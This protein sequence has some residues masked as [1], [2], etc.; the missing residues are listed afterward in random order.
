[1]AKAKDAYSTDELTSLGPQPIYDGYT[2]TQVAFPLGGIGTG[3]LSLTARGSLVDWE[4]FNRPNKGSVLPYSFFTIW[5]RAEG[6]DPVTRV[7]QGPPAPPFT[8]EGGGGYRGLGFGVTREDG[9]GLPHMRS[10][11]FRGEFPLAWVDFAD[12]KL[13]VQVK[14]EAYSP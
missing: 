7:L 14:L 2:A 8:G 1:M 4:I 11:T 10:A 9:S 12:P 6:Q 13:P 5:A 3:C